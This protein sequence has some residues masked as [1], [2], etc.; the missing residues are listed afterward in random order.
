M[1]RTIYIISFLLCA[2]AR[3]A[4]IGNPVI[5]TPD[6]TTLPS[7][8]IAT[9]AQI[10][11]VSNSADSAYATAVAAA[12]SAAECKAATTLYATNY[13]VT[14]TVYVQ[15][16][17][18]VPFDLSNQT[19][20]V[21]SIGTSSTNITIVATVAQTP[22]V[23]PSLDWRYALGSGEWSNITA[24]VTSINIPEG[25]TNAAAAYSF[26]LPM[27]NTSNAFFRVVDNSS[28]ASGSGLW[29]LVYG[30]I[31]VDG[32][33]GWTGVYTNVIDGVTNAYPFVGGILVEPEPMGGE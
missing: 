29:W 27:P 2:S 14:S 31:Y 12:A 21:Y 13:V 9:P 5:I 17:G 28:G 22:L 33:R 25:V 30:G 16:I 1:T 8:T 18:G 20:R 26:T 15:S 10:A 3:A 7:N 19:V 6:G 11:S 23:T 32:K 24:T 4:L